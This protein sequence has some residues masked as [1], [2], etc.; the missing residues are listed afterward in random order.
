MLL[1]KC[2][3]VDY[4][5]LTKCTYKLN[6]FKKGIYSGTRSYI[7]FCPVGP[8]VEIFSFIVTLLFKLSLAT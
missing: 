6:Y 8:V 2:G 5:Q 1:L 4:G 7:T 3:F